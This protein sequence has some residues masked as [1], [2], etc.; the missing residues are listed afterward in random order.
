MRKCSHSRHSEQVWSGS[1]A[2]KRGKLLH[3]LMADKHLLPACR[4]KVTMAL[5]VRQWWLL[6]GK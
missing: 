4:L 2:G 6:L 1:D 5:L 3:I